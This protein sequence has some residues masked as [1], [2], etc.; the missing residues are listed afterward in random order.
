MYLLTDNL[1][2]LVFQKVK[3]DS[4][5]LAFLNKKYNSMSYE[6]IVYVV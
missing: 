1:F 6:I 3:P 2:R 5:K 4:D